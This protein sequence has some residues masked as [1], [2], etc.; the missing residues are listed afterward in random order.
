MNN[1]LLLIKSAVLFKLSYFLQPECAVFGIKRRDEESKSNTECPSH[2][3]LRWQTEVSSSIY[4]T[5]VISDI[6]G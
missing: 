1:E 2:V 6:N 5:P 3:E 4:S